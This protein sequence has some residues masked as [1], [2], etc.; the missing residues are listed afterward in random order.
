[1]KPG[2]TPANAATLPIFLASS[3][4]VAITVFDVCFARTIS[5]SLI[6]FAGE[7]KCR[8]MTACGRLVTDR[9]LVDVQ[10]RGVGRE[11]RAGFADAS[12][13]REDLLLDAHVL[14][15]GFDD[16][17]AIAR[18]PRAERPVQQAHAHS[19]RPRA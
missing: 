18:G 16:E 4:D 6:T 3:I 1:M 9:D 19:R 17:I 12:S 5:S 13:L 2:H 15:H 11:D 8:P 7:K 14:E 10:R